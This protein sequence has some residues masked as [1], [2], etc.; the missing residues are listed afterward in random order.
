MKK[1][2]LTNHPAQIG[3]GKILRIM[4][5]TAFLIFLLVFDVSASLYSQTTKISVNVK[6]MSLSRDF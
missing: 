3:W 1:K 2:W 5:L 6:D 4:K